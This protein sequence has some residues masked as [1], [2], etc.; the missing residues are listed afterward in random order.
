MKDHTQVTPPVAVSAQT[1]TVC[2]IV[3]LVT[4]R[5]SSLIG[6]ERGHSG[7]I[8]DTDIIRESFVIS[9]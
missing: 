8:G 9:S 2:P 4:G 7:C 3:H 1:P 6:P 5:F